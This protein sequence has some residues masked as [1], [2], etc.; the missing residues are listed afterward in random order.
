MRT[1]RASEPHKAHIQPGLVFP[2]A[3]ACARAL[4]SK[5]SPRSDL[6]ADFQAAVDGDK[7][8]TFAAMESVD[9]HT[10]ASTRVGGQ[11]SPQ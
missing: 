10:A 5:P 8:S 3:A 11:G 6:I 7:R 4:R 9:L 2:R 1:W